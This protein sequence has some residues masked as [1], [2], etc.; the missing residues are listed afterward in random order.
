MS[1]RARIL[2]TAISYHPDFPTGA[3][4]LAYDE[5]EYLAA[6]G[7]EVWLVAPDLIG[8]QS[9]YM[10]RGALRVLRYALPGYGRFDPRMY[11]AHQ[12][13]TRAALLRHIPP[14]GIDAVHGHAVLQFTG[15]LALYGTKPRTAFTVHSP[16]RLEKWTSALAAPPLARLNLIM[17]GLMAH[18]I[19]RRAIERADAVSA[20]SE[21]TRE[22]IRRAHGPVQ[23]GR[24][25]VV[26]GWVDLEKYP[27]PPGSDLGQE[28]TGMADRRSG[29]LHPEAPGSAHGCGGASE[30]PC[31]RQEHTAAVQDGDRRCRAPSQFPGVPRPQPGPLRRR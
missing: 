27:S 24:T 17:A 30:G 29:A 6:R 13:C 20:D 31:H 2:I 18:R 28:S 9:E 21:Y 4:R 26:P 1:S 10:E 7:H 23:A 8:G 12:Q 19:E 22:L 14:D 25:H 16:V 3:S 5:A 11:A 15:A